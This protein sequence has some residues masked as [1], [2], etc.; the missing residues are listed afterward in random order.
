MEVYL[1]DEKIKSAVRAS[2]EVTSFYNEYKMSSTSMTVVLSLTSALCLLQLK[3][4]EYSIMAGRSEGHGR[5]NQA[6]A[7]RGA[8]F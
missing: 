8:E 6:A 4:R 2:I 1:H 7:C 5:R 3:Q